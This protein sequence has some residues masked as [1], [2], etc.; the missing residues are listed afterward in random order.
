MCA[1]IVPFYSAKRILDGLDLTPAPPPTMMPAANPPPANLLKSLAVAAAAS[2][3]APAQAPALS[4]DED[5]LN[6]SA[7]VP[8]SKDKGKGKAAPAPSSSSSSEEE[9]SSDEDIIPPPKDADVKMASLDESPS[10]SPPPQLPKPGP[11]TASTTSK[12][13]A[14]PVSTTSKPA[15]TIS[16]TSFPKPPSRI[17]S[18]PAHGASSA[19]RGI[20]RGKAAKENM[21]DMQVDDEEPL[22][23]ERIACV[24]SYTS[25]NPASV[26]I[27][28]TTLTVDFVTHTTLSGVLFQLSQNDPSIQEPGATYFVWLA[29]FKSWKPCRDWANI[30]SKPSDDRMWMME[31]DTPTIYILVVCF[32]TLLSSLHF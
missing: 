3:T 28:T 32:S 5:E 22:E 24:I 20:L 1:Y 11:S 9:E 17:D 31:D 30:R 7:A 10:P 4:E 21:A 16:S 18:I 27:T 13:S 8:P 12:H 25:S 19:D 23:M 2:S 6:I 14:K 29:K 15:S 26:D